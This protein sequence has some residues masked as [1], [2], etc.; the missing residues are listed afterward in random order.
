VRYIRGEDPRVVVE[1]PDEFR[2]SVPLAWTDRAVPSPYKLSVNETMR[3]SGV[4]LL[5]VVRLL[6]RWQDVP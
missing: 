2:Q 5:D 6:E 4:A 3:L 1:I